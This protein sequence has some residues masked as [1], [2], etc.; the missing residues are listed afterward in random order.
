MTLFTILFI[1]SFCLASGFLDEIVCFY[2]CGRFVVV[3]HLATDLF[4]YLF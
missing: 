4:L 3:Y 1:F 2:F